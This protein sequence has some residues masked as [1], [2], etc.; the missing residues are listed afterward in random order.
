MFLQKHDSSTES[1]KINK[2]LLTK[3]TQ[4]DLRFFFFPNHN[5]LNRST[6]NCFIVKKRNIYINTYLKLGICSREKKNIKLW[7]NLSSIVDTNVIIISQLSFFWIS[8]L[9]KINWSWYLNRYI[10]LNYGY[11]FH[12]DKY[13]K[14]I[15]TFQVEIQFHWC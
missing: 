6:Q 13:L 9:L 12:L 4:L 15:F 10:K 5:L 1:D 11:N 2:Y 7:I 14:Q 3:N 8:D